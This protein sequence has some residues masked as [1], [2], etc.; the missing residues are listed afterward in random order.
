M[1]EG[2][3][4]ELAF[5]VVGL[6]AGAHIGEELLGDLE[7]IPPADALGVP[8]GLRCLDACRAVLDSQ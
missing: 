2:G 3:P 7:R 5:G 6:D 1:L 8:G 4:Q